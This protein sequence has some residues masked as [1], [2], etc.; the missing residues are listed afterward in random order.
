MQN[1]HLED[2][3]DSLIENIF[4]ITL[5]SDFPSDNNINYIELAV[6]LKLAYHKESF[7]VHVVIS[8]IKEEITNEQK[9]SIGEVIDN[10]FKNL[11]KNFFSNYIISYYLNN[12]DET[13]GKILEE[14]EMLYKYLG[15]IKINDDKYHNLYFRIPKDKKIYLKL[16]QKLELDK[17][18]EP[19]YFEENE[20]QYSNLSY[21]NIS[22]KEE[23]EEE[24]NEEKIGNRTKE[25]TIEYAVLKV[26]LYDIIRK[27]SKFN[28]SQA[29][30]A[31]MIH[32]PKKTLDDYKKKIIKA[33][34]CDFNFNLHSKK[35]MN[36]L[37]DFINVTDPGE[38]KKK[39]K[40]NKKRQNKEK[41]K[42]KIQN[43]NS[44]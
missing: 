8:V 10:I 31:K 20:F 16:R 17:F 11:D 24:K 34:V 41:A 5:N 35:M 32:I 30:V 28:I 14:K 26:F 2:K 29:D 23:E 33:R 22:L 19:L 15:T 1:N 7:K 25:K 43:E 3:K 42:E 27:K 40:K 37:I 18:Y 4:E 39:I 36:F 44:G 6:F 9:F 13:E 12:D 21:N 38:K